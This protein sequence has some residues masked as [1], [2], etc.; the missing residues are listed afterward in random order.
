VKRRKGL[1]RAEKQEHTRTSLLRAASRLFCRRGLEGTSIDEIAESAGYTKG[2]FYANFKSKEELFLVMLDERFSQE[3]DRLDQA[4]AGTDDPDKEARTAAA[5]FVHFAS[6]DEWPRLYF[7]F[8][9]HAARNEDF[10]QEFATRQRAMRDRLVTVYERWINDYGVDP[11]LPLAEIAAMTYFM[12][13]G[14]LVDR[15]IEPGLDADLYP[16]MLSVFFRGLAAMAIGW[17]PSAELEA[18]S[19]SRQV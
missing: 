13:D 1:S 18:L 6:G 14:F 12:A 10:R 4:L 7:Q 16:T 8:A 9:A 3:L 2:A 5:E 17:E 19:R 11:P 15:L